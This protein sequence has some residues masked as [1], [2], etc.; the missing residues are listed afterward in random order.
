MLGLTLKTNLLFG[1]AQYKARPKSE[2]IK[3]PARPPEEVSV[4]PSTSHSMGNLLSVPLQGATPQERYV[5]WDVEQSTLPG[6]T[7]ATKLPKTNLTY[8]NEYE[9]CSISPTSS[10]YHPLTQNNMPDQWRNNIVK[11]RSASS[12]AAVC[13]VGDVADGFNEE[14][15]PP[16]GNWHTLVTIPIIQESEGIQLSIPCGF[17]ERCPDEMKNIFEFPDNVLSATC[18]HRDESMMSGFTFKEIDDGEDRMI[19]KDH[20]TCPFHGD[21]Y[22]KGVD[23]IPNIS[24]SS[25]P[26]GEECFDSIPYI[27]QTDDNCPDAYV[28]SED[29]DECKNIKEEEEKE[30]EKKEHNVL[31]D[32][33]RQDE[34]G[35]NKKSFNDLFSF[36]GGLKG[37]RTTHELGGRVEISGII[38]K[39]RCCT[40][41]QCSLNSRKISTGSQNDTTSSRGDDSPKLS[42]SSKRLSSNE[43]ESNNNSDND[44]ENYSN[45]FTDTT[46]QN[47]EQELSTSELITKDDEM[48]TPELLLD[49]S[50]MNDDAV[51]SD[52]SSTGKFWKSPDE[53]RLGCGRVATLA[54]HFSALGDGGLIKMRSM[55]LTRS[56]QFAS[57]PDITSPR[58]STTEIRESANSKMFK[59]EPDLCYEDK[60]TQVSPERRRYSVSM[61]D[62]GDLMKGDANNDDD[63]END[64]ILTIKG[65]KKKLSLEE[66][67]HIIE[68]IK[69][70]SNL[71]NAD[72]PLCLPQENQIV[73]SMD[74]SESASCKS[75]NKKKTTTINGNEAES[76]L[77]SKRSRNSSFTSSSASNPESSS[78]NNS[79]D[80]QETKRDNKKRGV[81]KLARCR[82][83]RDLSSSDGTKND[84]GEIDLT[85]PTLRKYF[86]FPAARSNRVVSAPDISKK[87]TAMLYLRLIKHRHDN[88][89]GNFM[90]RGTLSIGKKEEE[91]RKKKGSSGSTN[92]CDL[93]SNSSLSRSS[94]LSYSWENLQSE[95]SDV[96]S[97]KKQRQTTLL[98]GRRRLS[99]S[100]QEINKKKDVIMT[101]REDGTHQTSRKLTCRNCC[102]MSGSSSQKNKSKD[103]PLIVGDKTTI[104]IEGNFYL[105]RLCKTK[106]KSSRSIG[107]NSFD[108]VEKSKSYPD[109]SQSKSTYGSR[110]EKRDIHVFPS[111]EIGSASR[112]LAQINIVRIGFMLSA[113]SIQLLHFYPPPPT[114][115]PS[116]LSL[117]FTFKNYELVFYD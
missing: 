68:Q 108:V 77:T 109:I 1:A 23:A 25:I 42:F 92:D 98:N 51:S 111:L 24:T 32:D 116:S 80:K 84:R 49:L 95:K 114:P 29:N 74:N 11:T 16:T 36:S 60:S 102:S 9:R 86:V 37:V 85:P 47:D 91:K 27:D 46:D 45:V 75:L 38:S 41:C 58:S 59:S 17:R 21:N 57:E 105:G 82:S 61:Y 43:L 103:D 26:F 79:S 62:D 52:T 7:T 55:K 44:E 106:T 40:V 110:K 39:E 107:H 19:N 64:G 56:R 4:P 20:W 14:R 72:A 10:S 113:V 15:M 54:K 90:V 96:V 35:N 101:S 18:E 31:S 28:E 33:T 65:K 104:D 76:L 3:T 71:D 78:K 53:V 81:C 70:F 69:E 100:N 13:P 30:E 89:D 87:A 63:N 8:L 48:I 50:G 117:G 67:R 73:D 94:K 6:A 66:Q 97:Y 12:S 5:G 22:V 88:N 34:S 112:K 115:L 93:D 83:L 99:K 2:H